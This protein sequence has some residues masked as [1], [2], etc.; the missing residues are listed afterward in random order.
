MIKPI[1]P[2]LICPRTKRYNVI[3]GTRLKFNEK[4][5]MRA[6]DSV[7]GSPTV[8]SS[9][10]SFAQGR[11]IARKWAMFNNPVAI[12]VDASRFDQHVSVQALQWE[13]SIYNAIFHDPEL[14]EALSHQLKNNISLFV[15]DKMI[16]FKVDGHRM[17]G[18]INTSMGN[19]LIMCGLMHHYFKTLGVRAELCNNGDDCVII[20]ENKDKHL[21]D[22]IYEHFLQFGFNMVTEPVVECLEKLEFC[23]SRPICVNG[24]WRMVRRPDSIAKDSHTLL[25]MLNAEDVK[26]FMSATAQCG[27]VLNSG[28]PILEA[29]YRCLYRS[30]GY[31]KVTE[32][33]IKAVIG[34]GNEEKLQ[35]RRNPVSIPVTDSTR[36][37]YW[38]SFGVD[39]KTQQIIERYYDDLTVSTQ[40]Q[41]VKLTTPHLQSILLEIPQHP[42]I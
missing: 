15:E 23:Q 3:L 11:I 31:K 34:Y 26:S 14:R 5:I 13:H 9:Y 2:R 1:A 21:F 19:K 18:D 10:D 40:L 20:C 12:G 37:S 27:L 25:S 33:Y 4:R 32:E 30:S 41:P 6:I 38:E 28:V 8:L 36:M 29:F 16:R 17:S 35:G 42:T 22:N 39:P 24:A 7:F